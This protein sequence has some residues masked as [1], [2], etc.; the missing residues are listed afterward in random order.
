M[1]A[2]LETPSSQASDD[3][4]KRKEERKSK[5]RVYVTYAAALFLF[6]G[7]PLLIAFFYLDSRQG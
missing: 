4:E 3:W 1:N 6:L 5:V 2:N 7:G